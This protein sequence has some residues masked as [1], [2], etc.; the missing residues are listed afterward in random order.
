VVAKGHAREAIERLINLTDL[1]EGFVSLAP[2]GIEVARD[3]R[4][5]QIHGHYAYFY[6]E[7]TCFFAIRSGARVWSEQIER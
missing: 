7:D 2:S 5:Y 6:A 4:N 1:F 3:Y